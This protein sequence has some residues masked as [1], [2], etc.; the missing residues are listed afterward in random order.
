MAILDSLIVASCIGLSG[1][2][3]T[4]CTSALQAGTKQTGIEQSTNSYERRNV[5][6]LEGKATDWFGKDAVGFVGGT[7]WAAKVAIEKKAS[8]GI[9]RNISAE[10]SKDLTQLVL[11]W[12]F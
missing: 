7:A 12:T 4:A 2:Q 3:N 9:T 6:K 1:Q 8:F 11:R 5:K 10:I